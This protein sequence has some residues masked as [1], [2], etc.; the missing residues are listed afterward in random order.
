MFFLCRLLFV[1]LFALVVMH[2]A[3][4][5]DQ[6]QR[7]ADRTSVGNVTLAVWVEGDRYG[8]DESR[9]SCADGA[10]H[11]AGCAQGCCVHCCPLPMQAHCDAPLA[12]HGAPVVRS[13]T[14]YAGISHAPLLPPPIV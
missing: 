8:A 13:A 11:A 3:S 12:A 1:S 5:C 10:C 4:A 7:V 9:A 2:D 14:P 6:V